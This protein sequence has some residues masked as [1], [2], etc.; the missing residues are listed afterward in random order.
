M[1]PFVTV[2]IVIVIVGKLFAAYAL[3]IY[4]TP[5]RMRNL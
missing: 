5:E 1:L 4:I 2:N 3:K